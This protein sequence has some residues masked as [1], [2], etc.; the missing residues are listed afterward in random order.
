MIKNI[1][2]NSNV[3]VKLPELKIGELKFGEGKCNNKILGSVFK[4]KL[5]YDIKK[6]TKIKITD[7]Q[8]TLTKTSCSYLK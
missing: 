1:L 3:T 5:F 2:T 6:P 8:V 7:N 4:E